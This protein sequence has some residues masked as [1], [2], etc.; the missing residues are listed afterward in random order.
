MDSITFCNLHSYNNNSSNA[1][2]PDDILRLILSSLNLRYRAIASRVCKNWHDIISSCNINDN[3]LQEQFVSTRTF[4]AYCCS[5]IVHRRICS[6]SL[7]PIVVKFAS[8]NTNL[9]ELYLIAAVTTLALSPA[10]FQSRVLLT[11]LCL[12]NCKFED[13]TFDDIKELPLMKEIYFVSIQ[14]SPTNFVKL[15]NNCP[16]I[17]ELTLINCYYELGVHLSGNGIGSIE[18]KTRNLRE[19]YLL[20]S[21]ILTVKLDLRACT[22]LHV[23]KIDCEYIPIGFPNDISSAF[24]C[25]KSLFL[26]SCKRLKKFKISSPELE[27]LTLSNMVDLNDAVIVTP[28]LR[29]F[30]LIDIEKVPN[31]CPIIGS[32]LMEVEIG[33]KYVTSEDR[34]CSDNIRS[35]IQPLQIKQIDLLILLSMVPSYKFLTDELFSYFHPRTL[36][37]RVKSDALKYNFILVLLD[38]LKGWERELENVKRC[39]YS[40]N[41]C[42]RYFLKGFKIVESTTRRRANQISLEFQW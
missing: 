18:I 5:R 10:I 33:F 35:N 6:H 15:I 19:F 12:K 3:V 25:L 1:L 22:K 32:S 7:Y 11:V 23:L 28:N 40:N 29:S 30:K 41:M 36:L 20:R 17:A 4:C 16:S 13:E 39:K 21:S 24:P 27:N 42:W 34:L 9:T 26:R 14:I 38:Q 8:D 31:S 37:V 2:L